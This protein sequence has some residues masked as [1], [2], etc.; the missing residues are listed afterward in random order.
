M[1]WLY[2]ATRLAR[3][4]CDAASSTFALTEP[5]AATE[6]AAAILTV[7]ADG[8]AVAAGAAVLAVS[9]W[10]APSLVEVK[11]S[12]SEPFSATDRFRPASDSALLKS[13]IDLTVAVWAEES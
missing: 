5:A 10:L 2:W 3:A 1:I 8:A 11:V 4:V 12:V 13:L 6:A 7:L 9:V